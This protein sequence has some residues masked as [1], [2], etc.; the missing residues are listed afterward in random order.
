MSIEITTAQVASLRDAAGQ[1][2][3]LVQVAICDVALDGAANEETFAL[4]TAGQQARIAKLDMCS[5]RAI[6]ADVIADAKGA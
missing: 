6:C 3:D 4:L 2:G 1:A 5:A